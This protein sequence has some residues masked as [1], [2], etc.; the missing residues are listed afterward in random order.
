MMVSVLVAASAHDVGI[1]GAA[2]P[3]G[4]QPERQAVA[5]QRIFSVGHSYT[6]GSLNLFDEIA[7][8]AGFKDH[9]LVGHSTIGGSTVVDHYGVKNVMAALAAGGVDVLLTTPIY[10]PDPGIEKFA[11]FGLEHNPDFRLFVMEF[12][13]PYDNYEPRNYTAGPKGSPTERVPPPRVDH[14]AATV[15]ELRKMHQRYFDEMDAHVVEINKRLGKPVVFVMPVGQ[16]VIALREKI[17][18]GQAPGL[19]TQSALFTDE[20]GHPA[21]PLTLLMVYCRHAVVYRRNPVGLPVPKFLADAEHADELNGLLQELAWDSVTHHPLSG[22][23][24]ATA[25]PSR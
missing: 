7:R 11:R 1:A 17:S 9:V 24:T 21:K 15:T 20:L 22:V 14:D 18:A 10:L 25:S 4:G 6:Y 13:L 19:K 2:E 5:D 3:S 23:T 12:W 8:S 16:A